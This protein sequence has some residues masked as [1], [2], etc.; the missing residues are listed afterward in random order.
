[1]S[2]RY[3][4]VER[5]IH[6]GTMNDWN[7]PAMMQGGWA[8]L[9]CYRLGD[10]NQDA[11][12]PPIW[13]AEQSVESRCQKILFE[14]VKKPH[15]FI[16]CIRIYD[17][18]LL[19]SK[20]NLTKISVSKFGE[21]CRIPRSQGIAGECAVENKL[22]VIDDAQAWLQLEFFLCCGSDGSR[23]PC[24]VPLLKVWRCQIQS[25]IW[26]KDRR[27]FK[28]VDLNTSVGSMW[29]DGNS[30]HWQFV[31]GGYRTHSI[32]CVPVRQPPNKTKACAVIQMCGNS[33]IWPNLFFEKQC[34]S[35]NK[36]CP[37]QR[38]P[39]SG[40]TSKNLMTRLGR[41]DDEDVQATSSEYSS[42]QFSSTQNPCVKWWDFINLQH[43]AWPR[44]V[45]I[46]WGL[47][48]LCDVC[49]YTTC[50]VFIAK[51]CHLALQKLSL[52]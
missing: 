45:I 29:I 33:T 48:D 13:I 8:A 12:V 42:K 25:G 31:V 2:I 52:K 47:G 21:L 43:L 46:W 20:W 9:Y 22:I 27:W 17:I 51:T 35:Q 44:L 7:H 15:L 1:M 36:T 24:I 4:D 19:C 34:I 10:G 11:S 41:F 23:C 28:F 3:L 37:G 40:S 49:G 6:Q 26:W 38:R 39:I 18:R 50:S 32:I 5:D 30:Q 14:K 16:L